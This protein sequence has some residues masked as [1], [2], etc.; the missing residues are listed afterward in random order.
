MN[1]IATNL[2][3]AVIAVAVCFFLGRLFFLSSL[4]TQIFQAYAQ[5]EDS[6]NRYEQIDAELGRLTATSQVAPTGKSPSVEKMLKPGE[7]STLLRL[8]GSTGGKSF[9]IN[10][11]DLIESFRFKPEIQETS[12]APGASAFNPQ[13][14]P[15][16]DEQ[17]MPVGSAAEDDEEWPGVEIVPTRL[18]FSTTF[19]TLGKFLSDAAQVMPVN[20]VRS[21]D[22]ILREEGLVK[23]TLVLN[24]PLAEEK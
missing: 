20:S 11:F 12:S 3:G 4:Q 19:R 13:Q 9:R 1:R 15:E 17:G 6:K 8:I 2:I 22:L 23:G 24:F 16:L 5:L 18:T 10:S 7:E 21:L 14:L